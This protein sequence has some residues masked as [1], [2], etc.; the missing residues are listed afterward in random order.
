MDVEVMVALK[1]LHNCASPIFFPDDMLSYKFMSEL[2]KHID[3]V[4]MLIFGLN[5]QTCN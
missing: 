4:N 1:N 2:Y 5:F 3:L